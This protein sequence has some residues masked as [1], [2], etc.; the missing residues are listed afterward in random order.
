MGLRSSLMLHS[1]IVLGYRN[2]A[3]YATGDSYFGAT[4]GR[5]A[6]RISHGGFSIGSESYVLDR[7]D[8]SGHSVH[9]GAH[10][11][12]RRIWDVVAMQDEPYPQICLKLHSKG[13]DM[14][15]PG[16]MQTRVTYAL[17]PEG[18]VTITYDSLVDAPCPVSLTNHSYF[19]LSYGDRIHDHR[20][21]LWASH[22]VPVD[23]EQLP[24]GD[25]VSLEGLG[26]DF[27]TPSRLGDVLDAAGGVDH[28][29]VLDDR[30]TGLK[31]CAMVEE[32]VSGRIMS[33]FTTYPVVLLYTGNDL[34]Q[35]S[36]G[37]DRRSGTQ[38]GGFCLEAEQ[39]PDS[40]NHPRFPSAI[41]D[42]GR[43][44]RHQIVYEFGVL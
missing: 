14:G 36:N 30:S 7:N 10:G 34:D 2:L 35:E 32:P 9:G 21:T 5:Y 26:M 15:Y 31:R 13:G 3:H 37:R 44:Y 23:G 16:N 4:I 38:Y 22:Y 43:W 1:T 19:N 18:R 41:H 27:R 39:Y 28:A 42:P 20:I 8:P 6:D 24:T 40:M 25:V 33:V 17:E 29:Y 12:S 11:F